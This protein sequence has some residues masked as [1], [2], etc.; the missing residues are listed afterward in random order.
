MAFSIEFQTET[1]P[2]HAFHCSFRAGTGGVAPLCDPLELVDG[3]APRDSPAVHHGLQFHGLTTHGTQ[4]VLNGT[5][6]TS[7]LPDTLS[8]PESKGVP[9]FSVV[10]SRQKVDALNLMVVHDGWLAI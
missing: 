4:Q 3:R 7:R 2:F 8:G 1:L 10:L 9:K 5:E 6:W